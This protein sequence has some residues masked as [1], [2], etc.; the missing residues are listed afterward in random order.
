MDRFIRVL[1]ERLVQ[2]GMEITNI[3][4]YIRNLVNYIVVNP[5][6]SVSELNRRLHLLGWDDMKLDD[7]TF[8]LILAIF[9]QDVHHR[10]SNYFESPFHRDHTHE[11]SH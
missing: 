7:Y 11:Q 5:S 9:E 8:Q 4:A 6:I 3:P 2:K 10:L 1:I